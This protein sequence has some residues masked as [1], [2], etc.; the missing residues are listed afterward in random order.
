MLTGRVYSFLLIFDNVL[1]IPCWHHQIS[2]RVFSM[3]KSEFLD[4]SKSENASNL[5]IGEDSEML[6][7]ENPD[8]SGSS[9]PFE[10]YKTQTTILVSREKFLNVACDAL[11][12]YKY[13]GPN[14]K[15]DLLL[16]CRYY[17][18]STSES[19]QI[20][21]NIAH[22]FRLLYVICISYSSFISQQNIL[23]VLC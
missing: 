5:A 18:V 19:I 9:V 7:P 8:A 12:A 11:S 10:L 1:F 13:V 3:M 2:K 22:I 17:P 6:N 20:R 23:K 16:A 14:Q 15:A 21:S 4:A